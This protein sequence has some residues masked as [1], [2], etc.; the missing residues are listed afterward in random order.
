MKRKEK[1]R[2]LGGGVKGTT[3]II[4]GNK[5]FCFEGFRAVSASS[6]DNNSKL[7]ATKNVFSTNNI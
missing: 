6:S 7:Q 1:G 2:Q 3:F 4:T 5:I